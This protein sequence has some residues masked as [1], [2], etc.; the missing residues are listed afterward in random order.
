MANKI[1][2]KFLDTIVTDST[3]WSC[4]SSDKSDNFQTIDPKRLII[5]TLA[6]IHPSVWSNN[7]GPDKDDPSIRLSNMPIDLAVHRHSFVIKVQDPLCRWGKRCLLQIKAWPGSEN[8]VY[9]KKKFAQIKK[10]SRTIP[11]ERVFESQVVAL[12][13]ALASLVEDNDQPPPRQT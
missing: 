5:V 2:R 3:V 13:K 11:H 7:Y 12:E 9:I 8:Y 6:F 1:V 10:K 4:Y